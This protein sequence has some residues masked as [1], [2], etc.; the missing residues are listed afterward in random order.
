MCTIDS[1]GRKILIAAEKATLVLDIAKAGVAADD[2]ASFA[3]AV[4][5]LLGRLTE[6]PAAFLHL[7]DS[8]GPSN[9]LFQTGFEPPAASAIE[10]L[11]NSEFERLASS[12]DGNAVT[13]SV[14]D[15][16]GAA[17][18]L[19]I[20]TLKGGADLSVL[21]GFEQ[22]GEPKTMNG[23]PVEEA[24]SLVAKTF[25]RLA[26][27]ARADRQ[28]HHLNTYLTVSSML[29]QSLGL[30]DLMESALYICKD[31]SGSAEASIMLLDDE[32]ENLCFFEVEGPSKSLL[33]GAKFPANKGL[34]GD[35]LQKQQS[36]IVNDVQNDPRFYGVIDTQSS[37]RTRNL[38]AVPLT[39]GE[40]RIG[41]MEVV[42]KVG[43]GSFS[44]EERLLLV[45]IA[46][47]LAFAIRNAKVF[48][49][50]VNAYCR[51]RQGET[52]C[53]GC[54]RPLGSWT[55]CVKYREEGS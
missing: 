53:R 39:A 11:C 55:P 24:L 13:V 21:A 2:P 32:K 16:A 26:E 48:E 29:S 4:L 28:I 49:V 44:E 34:A 12:P 18:N 45:S 10:N 42:N 40:E 1:S 14:P 15:A 7:V 17:G 31:V 51:L 19:M 52:S 30:R 43:G 5:P 33:V 22:N 25:A 20:R 23:A 37:F 41:V 27:K 8:S 6:S 46:E 3:A 54:K 50:A 36:E 9:R 38:I 35:V 47:E